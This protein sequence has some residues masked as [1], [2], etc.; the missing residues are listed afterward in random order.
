MEKIKHDNFYEII[1]D[2]D[3]P[4]IMDEKF[5]SILIKLITEISDLR[6][7]LLLCYNGIAGANIKDMVSMTRHE[8]FEFS[9]KGSDLIKSIISSSSVVIGAFDKCLLGGGLELALACDFV[10]TTKEC[11][12]GFPEPKLGIIPGFL[13]I[14]SIKKRGNSLAKEL[15]F[16]GRIF[17]AVD[18][19]YY[20]IFSNLC[21]D[22]NEILL[23]AYRYIKDISEC[24]LN[25]ISI[26][27]SIYN[28]DND[29]NNESA[30]AN[31]HFSN[32]FE[33]KDQIEGM[34][35]FIEKRAPSFKDSGV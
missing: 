24:S 18:L 11:R 32:L 26:V 16:T 8:A 2:N 14:Q 34:N 19:S 12:I 4:I 3:K 27:K 10:L 33:K 21:D 25:S 15:L 23:C 31:L 7:I 9:R 5:I 17:N 28:N 6:P 13:G 20:S 22:W 35:A 29:N 30:D 1:L